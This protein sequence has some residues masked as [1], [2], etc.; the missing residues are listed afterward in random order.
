MSK[1]TTIIFDLS[2]VLA[3]GYYGTEEII[4]SFTRVSVEDFRAKDRETQDIF[5]DTMRGKYTEK[6]YFDHLLSRA[7]WE[8]SSEEL[9]IFVR[10]NLSKRLTGSALDVVKE[11]KGRYRL[12]LLSDHVREWVE[13]LRGHREDIF[14]LFDDTFF[15]CDLG[16]LKNDDPSALSRVLDELGATPEEC[17]FVDDQES[18]IVVAGSH[19]ISSILYA[20]PVELQGALDAYGITV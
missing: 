18:N 14:E 13:F 19:G 8:L 7:K 11:L 15:S 6:E 17:L 3:P 1:I 2:E 20:T 5:R 10:I 9:S 12:V 4:E 16:L